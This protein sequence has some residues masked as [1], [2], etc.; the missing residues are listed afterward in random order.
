MTDQTRREF[1]GTLGAAAL[2][3]PL[4]GSPLTGMLASGVHA[5]AAADPPKRGFPVRTRA[6]APRPGEESLRGGRLRGADDT[7]RTA[8][9]RRRDGR[10]PTPRRAGGHS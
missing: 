3:P 5:N 2:V 6:G 8:P 7:G 4:V 1:L 9:A 10:T